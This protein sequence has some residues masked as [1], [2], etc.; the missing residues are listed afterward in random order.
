MAELTSRGYRIPY[1]DQEL[2]KIKKELMVKPFVVPDF[3]FGNKPF[4]V[5]R[6]NEKYIYIPKHYGIK[7]YGYPNVKEHHE[8]HPIQV[9]FNGN[10]KEKQKKVVEPLLD[11][12]KEKESAVLSV[13]CG[14]GKCLAYDTEI[15]MYDG[16]T[17]KVQ[18]IT[19][20]DK[21]MGDDSKPRNVLSTCTGREEMY[22]I[23]PTR[24]ESYVVNESH[25]LSLKYN[26][27]KK[28]NQIIDISVEDYLNL[29]KSTS[30]VGYRVGVEFSKKKVE[31]DPYLFGFWLVG[32]FI[33]TTSFDLKK[34]MVNIIEKKLNEINSYLV[35]D[36]E[37]DIFII[38]GHFY[39][40]VPKDTNI[41][42]HNYKCN[43][44][45][46]RLK[47]LAGIL[48]NLGYYCINKYVLFHTSK[49]LLQD[50]K[51]L[52]RSLGFGVYVGDIN[53]MG[54]YKLEIYGS[55]LYNIP[56]ILKKSKIT[57]TTKN[58][59]N[60]GIKVI[61]KGV[62]NYYGF[63]ID[64]NRRF[65]LSTFDVTHNTVCTLWLASQLGQKTMVLVHKEFLLN[66]WVDRI[67]EFL[68]G[69]R[70][71]VLQQDR[72][73]VEDK[74]IV[75]GMI[76]SI[77]SRKYPLETYRGIGLLA[78]DESHRVC[79]RTFSKA[80]Y[81]VPT[82]YTLGLSATPYRKDGLTKILNWFMGEIIEPEVDV[83]SYVPS[84]RFVDAEYHSIPEIKYNVMG[85]INRPDLITQIANDEG[86]NDMIVGIIMELLGE[87]RKILL[88][89]ERRSQCFILCEKLRTRDVD[90]GV[91]VGGMSNGDL[92]V[93]N[94]CRV[95]LATY[96]MCS[97]GYDNKEIDTLI[98]A[99]G[100]SDIEQSVGR[101]MRQRNKNDPLVVD[102][103]D[104]LDGLRGQINVRRRFYR[105]RK[106]NIIGE[107]DNTINNKRGYMFLE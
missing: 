105:G 58:P 21:L 43:N 95:I 65:L 23:V 88:L 7:K 44:R 50:I 74:D 18:D 22:E 26:S 100:R 46:N 72:V 37:E 71:G 32:C 30:L 49:S 39:D 73:E 13:G 64:G 66:Q 68:P 29:P 99:T 33:S 10:L 56:C 101:I 11:H 59:L 48:D 106:Y 76:Q 54:E 80:L 55:D 93:S 24:G 31:M 42:P 38:E 51:Y 83:K 75:I 36:T 81:M 63:E 19:I 103:M 45:K 78:V 102:I 41:I 27:G 82:R 40:L 84:V 77:V 6:K 20:G 17:K 85:K 61:P 3:D 86:R 62:D 4:P 104:K 94:G 89:T 2:K 79:S 107:D 91:Y 12:I 92:E 14:F 69:A 1:D 5:Y 52:G 8:I 96:S 70:V 28:K 15:L 60:Y 9:E 25:I 47:L 35:Y 16:T 97:E 57:K 98:M 53:T 67:Q 90:V 87:D 34:Y